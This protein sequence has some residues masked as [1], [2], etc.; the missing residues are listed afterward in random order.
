MERIIDRAMAEAAKAQY[1]SLAPPGAA[2]TGGV[3][4]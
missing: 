4:A 2:G 1:A 3:R